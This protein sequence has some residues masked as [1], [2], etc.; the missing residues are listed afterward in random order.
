MPLLLKGGGGGDLHR[1]L[2]LGTL[3]NTGLFPTLPVAAVGYT[4]TSPN[5]G[6]ICCVQPLL[7][8]PYA[9]QA[10]HICS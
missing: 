4:F 3:P 10:L 5:V 6:S 9:I 1:L 7:D 2:L 8:D